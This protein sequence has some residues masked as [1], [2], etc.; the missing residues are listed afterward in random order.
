MYLKKNH[1]C[2]C[3]FLNNFI[4]ADLPLSSTFSSFLSVL[5]CFGLFYFLPV[6]IGL[7]K[8][9]EVVVAFQDLASP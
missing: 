9:Q 6:A 7:K 3:L 2:C 5:K 4:L 8:Q 1:C